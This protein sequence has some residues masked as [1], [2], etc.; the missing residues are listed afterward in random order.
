MVANQRDVVNTYLVLDIHLR[1][2]L[3]SK[4]KLLDLLILA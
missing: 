4:Q 1:Q 3:T 2:S